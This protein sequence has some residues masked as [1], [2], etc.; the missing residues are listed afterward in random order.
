MIHLQKDVF[1][2]R[3]VLIDH[4]EG[5]LKVTFTDFPFIPVII[6]FVLVLK[7]DS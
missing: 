5:F 2:V 3:V 4:M 6:Q 1:V 7:N